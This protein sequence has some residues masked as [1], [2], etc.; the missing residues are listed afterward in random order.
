M[1]FSFGRLPPKDLRNCSVPGGVRRDAV[2]PSLSL[3]RTFFTSNFV[4]DFGMVAA[5]FVGRLFSY[6]TFLFRDLFW[7]NFLTDF[8]LCLLP[9]FFGEPS[10]TL[11]LPGNSYDSRPCTFF[12]TLRI[13]MRSHSENYRKAGLFSHHF[14]SMFMTFR[15]SISV[16]I[17]SL[18]LDGKWFQN[19][20]KNVTG[21]DTV[22]ELELLK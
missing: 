11:I 16:S 13:F 3:C 6:C 20:D 19:W 21:I 15:A 1:Y 9:F 12:Q 14:S 8:Q 22:C 2:A 4:N 5:S 7:E 18:I 10:A 17:F